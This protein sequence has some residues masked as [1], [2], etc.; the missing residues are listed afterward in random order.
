MYVYVCRY[1]LLKL[2]TEANIGGVIFADVVQFDLRKLYTV[3][4]SVDMYAISNFKIL[5]G[6][7]I[8]KIL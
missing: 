8:T 3:L 1:I 5:H 6:F 2:R 4:N 7:D